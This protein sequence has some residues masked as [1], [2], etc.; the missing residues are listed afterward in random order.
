VILR[1]ISAV[2][3]TFAGAFAGSIR[4]EKLRHDADLCREIIILI[5]KI[6]FCIRYKFSDV[7]EIC[8]ELRTAGFKYLKFITNLP[9]SY[10]CGEDFHFLWE[11]AVKSQKDI[12]DKEK[13]ILLIIGT[14]VG[15]SDAESQ[16]NTFS[17]LKAETELLK[18]LRISEYDKKGRLFRSIGVL[19]GVM[20]G[21]LVI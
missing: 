15:T 21:I 2:F 5:E 18:S 14:T 17:S 8:S 11:N 20:A 13:N 16:I 1:F 12:P 7:Y 3:F 10:D 19:M 4:A 9:E 6:S